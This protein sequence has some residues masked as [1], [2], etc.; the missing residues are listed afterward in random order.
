MLCYMASSPFIL[1]GVLLLSCLL[2]KK[3]DEAGGCNGAASLSLIAVVSWYFSLVFF[4][5]YICI[6]R[7]DSWDEEYEEPAVWPYLHLFLSH[8]FS[9]LFLWQCVVVLFV[10]IRLLGFGYFPVRVIHALAP[11]ES[12]ASSEC[13]MWMSCGWSR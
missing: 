1:L 10:G 4:V 12:N 13:G 2:L 9:V 3:Q 8:L 5:A 6:M 11:Y 7:L